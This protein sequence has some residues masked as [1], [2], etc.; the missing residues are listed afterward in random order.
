[1]KKFFEF[2]NLKQSQSTKELQ[3]LKGVLEEEGFSVED[4]TE[5][6]DDPYIFVGNPSGKLSFNGIRIYRL[7]EMVAYRIQKEN[8]THPYGSAY[9]LPVEEMYQRF[10]SEKRDEKKAGEETMKS[11]A[12][13][14]RKFFKK[15][16]V[17]E[18]DTNKFLSKDALG[19]VVIPSTGTDYAN[20]I[21]SK[22]K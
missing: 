20:M 7:G 2:V 8:K 11:I 16:E 3:I 12:E 6:A 5:R 10:L 15:S 19:R 9:D 22:D 14:I 17:A 1:M 13:E 18:K 21:F 4:F